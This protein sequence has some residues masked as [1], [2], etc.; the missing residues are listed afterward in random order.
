MGER[1]RVARREG[2]GERGA[3]VC[4]DVRLVYAQGLYTLTRVVVCVM[5][6]CCHGDRVI[7][8]GWSLSAVSGCDMLSGCF[9]ALLTHRGSPFLIDSRSSLWTGMRVDHTVSGV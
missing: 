8:I 1:F 7:C 5:R 2:V 9:D 6:C 3:V 4:G